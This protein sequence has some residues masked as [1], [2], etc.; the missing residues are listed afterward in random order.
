M[1]HQVFG[2]GK[3]TSSGILGLVGNAIDNVYVSGRKPQNPPSYKQLQDE[4]RSDAY[5]PHPMKP[6]KVDHIILTGGSASLNYMKTAIAAAL[7]RDSQVSPDKTSGPQ[8]YSNIAIDCVRGTDEPQ[9]CVVQGLLA[10]Y[11]DRLTTTD[12]S[13]DGGRKPKLA[14]L[15]RLR[16][17]RHKISSSFKS[18]ST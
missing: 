18:K 13:D 7:R 9:L 3:P 12:P 15:A 17:L 10:A 2:D 11:M 8:K 14:S 1:D 6:M 4:I 5:L 16:E